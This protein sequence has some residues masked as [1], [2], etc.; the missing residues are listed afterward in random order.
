ME[1][2]EKIDTDR[3]RGGETRGVGRYVLAASLVLI[4]IAFVTLLIIFG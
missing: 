1:E 4:V 3:A 2:P